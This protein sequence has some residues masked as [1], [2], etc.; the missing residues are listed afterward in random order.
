MPSTTKTTRSA[1]ASADAAV[2][3]M[4][5]L[6]ARFSPRCRPGVSTKA[7]WTPGRLS[8]PSTRWRVVCGRDV[9]MESFS[10]T[11]ALSSVDL[12]TLGRPTSAAN[13]ARNLP[14]PAPAPEVLS[15]VIQPQCLQRC[16]RGC[17]FGAPT[18]RAFAL[19]LEGRL[20]DGAGD[21]EGLSVWL[22]ARA[23]DGV[24]RQRARV[25]L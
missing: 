7:I 14:G 1:S 15:S 10:P 4:A 22:A 8:M 11:S 9:T 18:A 23:L 2:R 25:A 16:L 3:F 6:R 12:P 21:Q 5:R 20:R 13:P 24:D 19:R 17:L